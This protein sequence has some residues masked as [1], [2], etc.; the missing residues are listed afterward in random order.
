MTIAGL[1]RELTDQKR[2]GLDA[3]LVKSLKLLDEDVARGK[4][5]A[6]SDEDAA[7]LS[8]RLIGAFIVDDGDF[9]GK[10]EI[11]WWSIP[12]LGRQDGK[13]AWSQLVGLP[14]GAP[15]VKCGD[16][17]WIR[18][19]SPEKPALLAVIPPN[20]EIVAAFVQLAFYDDDGAKAN[21]PASMRAALETLAELGTSP[22]ASFSEIE[23]PIRGAL[24]KA[25]AAH[26]DDR[27]LDKEIRLLRGEGTVRFDAGMIGSVVT[28]LA[29]AYYFV[30]D[31]ER[32]EQIGPVTLIKGQSE[33]LKFK[34]PPTGGTRIAIFS[35]G[36]V[37]T[38]LGATT[39]DRPFVNFI[40]DDQRAKGLASGI[41]VD[42]QG[43]AE[44]VV[45]VTP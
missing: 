41:K 20:P 16:K 35:R 8:V 29:H 39:V 25:L 30:R 36:P 38:T 22:K 40:V 11:Y 34:A 45:Y 13:V 44:V 17:Q 23:K 33:T 7:H 18:E 26:Q 3:E 14:T 24:T 15:P 27:L 4:L 2:I 1:A 31:E 6:E 37:E 42:A 43:P 21:V 32:T 9:L 10:G 12:A 5:R 19:P 28:P